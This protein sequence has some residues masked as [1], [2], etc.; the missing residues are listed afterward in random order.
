MLNEIDIQLVR[1]PAYTCRSLT[2]SERHLHTEI[3]KL[4]LRRDVGAGKTI[5]NIFVVVTCAVERAEDSLLHANLV[6]NLNTQEQYCHN[7]VIL[8]KA[9][10]EWTIS[11]NKPWCL[12]FHVYCSLLRQFQ[13][14]MILAVSPPRHNSS[15]RTG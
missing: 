13:A 7:L 12:I 8:S 2:L 11:E 15:P 6:R 14:T 3:G 5:K 4:V 1:W 9:V 10:D